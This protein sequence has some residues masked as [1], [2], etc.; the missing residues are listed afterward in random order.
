MNKSEIKNGGLVK[1][2]NQLQKEFNNLENQILG[3]SVEKEKF[4]NSINE[5]IEIIKE[6]KNEL[7]RKSIPVNLGDVV[8][9]KEMVDILKIVKRGRGIKYE[10]IGSNYLKG[11]IEH[12]VLENQLGECCITI[13]PNLPK[14]IISELEIPKGIGWEIPR[15]KTSSLSLK[16][17]NELYEVIKN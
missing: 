3:L 2:S 10:L 14:G 9:T 6:K 17:F 13:K 16:E 4:N 1:N 8:R 7:I 12:I 11:T 15:D 5:K